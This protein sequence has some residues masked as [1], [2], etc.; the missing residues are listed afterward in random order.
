MKFTLMG[1]G[2]SGGTPSIGN[3]W[4]VCDPLE[5]RN[6][7]TRSAGLVRSETTTLLIDT[8]PDLREQANRAGIDR[9]DAVIYTHAHADHIS[10]IEELR[11]FQVRF[12]KRVPIYGDQ[13]TIAELKS[14]SDY[15]FNQ[16]RDFYPA[17][18]SPTVIEPDQMGAPMAI[19][20]ISFTPFVQGHG[21][22]ETLGFRFGD[23]AYSTDM[24]EMP[25]AAMEA[26]K[27]IKTWIVD[28][29]GYNLESTLVHATLAQI[30]ALN[31]IIGAEQVYVT[32]L[33]PSMDYQTLLKELPAG[34]LPAYDGMEMEIRGS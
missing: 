14:R 13:A 20:D 2:N 27:G 6:R 32:H 22:C 26:V 15:L 33:P 18:V 31:E 5:P 7:R 34:Y 23:L 10:G 29:A 17:V 19:G 9:A 28:A 25:D 1:C 21:T 4:G 11:A 8:G 3:Y 24:V 12:K 16:H 30:Y